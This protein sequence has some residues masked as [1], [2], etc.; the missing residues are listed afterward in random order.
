MFKLKKCFASFIAVTLI[1]GMSNFAFAETENS[2]YVS[3]NATAGGD[4]S[5]E[6]PFQ[7]LEEAKNKAAQ[8]KDEKVTIYIRG[9]SYYFDESLKFTADDSRTPDAPLTVMAYNDEIVS[10]VGGKLID[11]TKFTKVTDGEILNRLPVEARGEVYSLNLKEQG[12]YD[13][14]GLKQM[15]TYYGS[16]LGIPDIYVN[17]KKTRVARWPNEGYAK[18]GVVIDPGSADSPLGK[19]PANPKGAIMEYEDER[20]S[21]WKN[22]ENAWLYGYWQNNYAV[23]TLRIKEID[24]EKKTIETVDSDSFGVKEGQRFYAFNLLE[25]LDSPGEWF[26]EGDILYYYP[27]CDLEEA[28]MLIS[29]VKDPLI[30]L[31]DC[32]NITFKDLIIECSIG[33]NVM[34]RDTTENIVFRGCVIRGS[35]G[36]CIWLQGKNNKV[37]NSDVYDAGADCIGLS[38]GVADNNVFELGNNLVENCDIHDFGQTTAASYGVL[39]RGHGNNV[40]HNRIHA[41]PAQ[42]IGAYGFL[43]KIEYNE[44]YDVL[45][46]TEDAGAIYTGRSSQH[47]GM[48]IS[49]N[50]IHDVLGQEDMRNGYFMGIY[51]D[52][53]ESGVIVRGNVLK[54]I[55]TPIFGHHSSQCI[56]ENNIAIN[57]TANSNGS[58]WW[59]DGGNDWSYNNLKNGTGTQGQ[60]WKTH[61][62][63][64]WTKEPYATLFP[65]AQNLKEENGLDPIDNVIRHNIIVNHEDF[66]ILGDVYDLSTIEENYHFDHDPGFVDFENDNFMLKPDSEIFDLI[67]D[68]ENPDVKKMGLYYDPERPTNEEDAD[69]NKLRFTLISPKDGEENVKSYKMQFDWSIC[70]EFGVDRYKLV[71]AKDR[72]FKDIV[73]ELEVADLSKEITELSNNTTYYWKVAAV[74][75]YGENKKLYWNEDGVRSFTTSYY[76][77]TGADNETKIKDF[78]EFIKDAEGWRE[79]TGRNVTVENDGVT[80][81]SLGT[82]VSGYEGAFT[83]YNTLYHFGVVLSPGGWKG[84]GLHSNNTSQVGWTRNSHYLIIIKENALEIHKYPENFKAGQMIDSVEKQ[85]A[86]DGETVNDVV[87]GTYKINDEQYVLVA[88]NGEVIYN[89]KDTYGEPLKN[90]GYLSVYNMGDGSTIKLTAPSMEMPEIMLKRT[91]IPDQYTKALSE[92]VAMKANVPRAYADLTET[93]V[94]KKNSDIT[95]IVKNNSTLLPLRFVAES[96]GAEVLWN[97]ETRTVN[98]NKNGKNIVM[99]IGTDVCTVNG[100]AVDMPVAAEI[101][102]NTTYLPLRFVAEMLD[103]HVEYDN[104]TRVILVIPKENAE[105]IPKDR[106]WWEL[107]EQYVR[108]GKEDIAEFGTMA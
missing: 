105:H 65:D 12:E 34:M 10:F 73:L 40:I 22:A 79:G 77:P 80:F 85:I 89:F 18:V 91:D 47:R 13:T 64:D 63:I 72:D 61:T 94:N 5:Y 28:E 25:E 106:A 74:S 45:R 27:N 36:R 84:I 58:I 52:D 37:I 2:Y 49:Y 15:G 54:N 4:G 44:I 24:T 43:S 108:L 59:S 99:T 76:S 98:V 90:D 38:G 3:A 7:T 26:M 97:E 39:M 53:Y 71:V 86:F 48:S 16:E 68:F 104:E 70:N 95:P 60:Y 81:T 41:G 88:L 96:V 17:G 56:V 1:S 57:K 78:S 9:G 32:S 107:L 82:S 92:G 20:I 87:F 14:G 31:T 69:Y 46:E 75:G 66:N 67:P 100:E 30:E 6:R 62:D 33:S 102:N 83:E 11:A 23:S 55:S 50:Y 42:A 103:Y 19:K 21:R 8:N 93:Q 35:A 29:Q 101:V 51:L